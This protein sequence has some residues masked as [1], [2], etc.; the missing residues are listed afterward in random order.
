MNEIVQIWVQFEFRNS[1][2]YCNNSK[3]YEETTRGIMQ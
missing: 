3:A 1:I 2:L